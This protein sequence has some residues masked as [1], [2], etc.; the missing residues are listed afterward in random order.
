MG[1]EELLNIANLPRLSE[2]RLHL[3][4]TEVFKIV[5]GLCYFPEDIF[6]MQSSHSSRLLRSDTLLCPFAKTN[7]YYHSFVPSAIRAWNS[8]DEDQVA[9]VSLQSFKHNIV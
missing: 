8:L 9:T 1:Y 3:K 5:H 4:L 7:Y 6:I 2:R